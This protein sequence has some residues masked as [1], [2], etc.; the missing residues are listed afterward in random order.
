MKVLVI[1]DEDAATRLMFKILERARPGIEVIAQI[2]SVEDAVEWLGNHTAPDLIFMDI[3]LGDGLSFEI[4]EKVDIS[5]PVVFTTAYDEYTLRAFK[6][7]SIDY[8]LKPLQLEDLELALKKYDKLRSGNNTEEALHPVSQAQIESILNL[9][10]P[11]KATQYKSRFLIKVGDKF[12]SVTKDQIAYFYT[13]DKSVFIQT[14]DKQ[15]YPIDNSLDDLDKILDPEIFF[16]INRQYIVHVD[17][18]SKLHNYFNGK[19][20]VFLKPEAQEEVIVSRDKASAL[21]LWLDR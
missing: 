7:N 14:H 9:L 17:A 5:C 8:L 20:K 12:F 11:A 2:D 15:R 10:N 18:V 16:R 1:E 13:E 3:Q 21:K 4:F 6:V 19:M